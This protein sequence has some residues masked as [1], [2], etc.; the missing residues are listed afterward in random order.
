MSREIKFRAWDRTAMQMYSWKSIQFNFYEHTVNDHI[1]VMQYTGLKDKN[2]TEIYEGDI[3]FNPV[4]DCS[5]VVERDA[6]SPQ[7]LFNDP[8][9]DYAEDYY[10]LDEEAEWSYI[11]IQGNIYENPGILEDN[12]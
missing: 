4:L 1:V 2:G 11:V 6:V 5:Y 8:N 3:L 7:I 10:D 12:Q 9:K